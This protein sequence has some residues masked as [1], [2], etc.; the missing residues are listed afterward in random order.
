MT[1]S[2]DRFALQDVMADYAA[3]VDERDFAR[4]RGCFADG[5]E[6]LGFTP[7]PIRGVT[8]WMEFVQKALTRYVAT[9]HLMGLQHAVIDGDRAHARTDVQAQHFLES[10]RG[11]TLT[12]WAT[13]QTDFARLDGR[14]RIVRHRFVPRGRFE[15]NASVEVSQ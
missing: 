4:Y 6:V 14:W 5:V 15:T 9:Q 12:V 2:A 3:G 10:P 13:Y 11:A 7:E 1:G 8:A